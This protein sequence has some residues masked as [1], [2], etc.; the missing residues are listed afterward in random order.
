MD[1][2][3]I[4][5]KTTTIRRKKGGDLYV[6]PLSREE[7]TAP[8]KWHEEQ[9]ASVWRYGVLKDGTIGYEKVK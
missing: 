3:K 2:Q 4:W 7:M 5:N 1:I 8:L 6:R 9:M